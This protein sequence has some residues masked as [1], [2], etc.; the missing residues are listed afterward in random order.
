MIYDIDMT[1]GGTIYIPSFIHVG[2]DVRKLLGEG[3]HIHTDS[4]VISQAYIYFL[5]KENGLKMCP[6]I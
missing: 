2:S 5:N 4:K 1:S 3:A 6:W